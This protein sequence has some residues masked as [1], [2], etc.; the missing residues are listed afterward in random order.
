MLFDSISVAVVE[1]WSVPP[2]LCC[3]KWLEGIGLGKLYCELPLGLLFSVL[4]PSWYNLC[5][6]SE[7][8]Q[9]K[10]CKAVALVWWHY[11]FVT[12]GAHEGHNIE[13]S[14]PGEVTKVEESGSTGGTWRCTG[15]RCCGVCK[16]LG[17]GHAKR[18][19]PPDLGITGFKNKA[20]APNTHGVAHVINLDVMWGCKL[21][22]NELI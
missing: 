7:R 5:S 17:H 15:I 2:W 1:S 13:K 9:Y 19:N 21:I 16:W 11:G 10:A 18:C 12:F 6:V 8:R 22:E 3:V 14:R 20:V 4:C